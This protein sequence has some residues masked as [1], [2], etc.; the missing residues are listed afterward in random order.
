M[1]EKRCR[2]TPHYTKQE[3][4]KMYTLRIHAKVIGAVLI[5]CR[6]EYRVT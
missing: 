6:T 2:E 1:K 5:L 4:K 3:K